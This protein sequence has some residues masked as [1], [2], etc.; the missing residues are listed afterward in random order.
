MDLEGLQNKLGYFFGERRILIQALTHTSYGHENLKEKALAFRNNERLEFLGDAVLGLIVSDLLLEAYPEDSEGQLSRLRA[1]LVNERT[2]SEIARSLGLN[3]LIRL[4]KGETQTG[5]Q[6]KPSILSSTFEALVAAVYLDGGVTG[7]YPVI[8]KIF[9]PLLAQDSPIALAHDPKTRLQE[10]VQARWKTTPVYQLIRA[11]GPD[12]AKEFEIEVSLLGNVL[13][14]AS[15]FSKK[16]AEQEAARR[17]IEHLAS[18]PHAL[19]LGIAG[20][21]SGV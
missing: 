21:V 14:R 3:F 15:G 9:A 17:A 11:Q 20:G 10:Q 18:D 8:R 5:G 16:E 2:L 1:A 19:S 13:A 6:G 4:G 7:V 12:H